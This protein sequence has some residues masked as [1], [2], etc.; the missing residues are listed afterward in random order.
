MAGDLGDGEYQDFM[1]DVI[2]EQAKDDC[3]ISCDVKVRSSK[4]LSGGAVL[5][6]KFAFFTCLV[7]ILNKKSG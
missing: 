2:V 6:Q 7:T 4:Y 1:R 3:A 5:Y